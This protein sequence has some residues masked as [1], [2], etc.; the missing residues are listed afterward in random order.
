MPPVFF[1]PLLGQHHGVEQ[2]NLSLPERAKDD[3]AA[4]LSI[5][6]RFDG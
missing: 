3:A 5:F 2:K 1:P 4:G 6:F